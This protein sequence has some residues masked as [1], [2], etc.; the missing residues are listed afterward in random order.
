MAFGPISMK[1]RADKV[2]EDFHKTANKL[3]AKH[4]T[5]ADATGLVETEM[6]SYNSGRASGFVVGA[7]G[8]V[9]M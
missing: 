1:E 5:H 2:H 9:S 4:G 7:F 8:E 3:D 6:N